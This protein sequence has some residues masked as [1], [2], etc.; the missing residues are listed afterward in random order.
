MVLGRWRRGGWMVLGK[1][2]GRMVLREV[3]GFFFKELLAVNV[4]RI[5]T[6]EEEDSRSEGEEEEGS[7]Q[8][9]LCVNALAVNVIII[10]TLEEEDSRSEEE[11]EEGTT[12]NGLCVNALAVN[13]IR[14]Q[15]SSIFLK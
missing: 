12:Q 11:E 6:L 10:Y 13:V 4:I 15:N 2:G 1:G 7:T 8:N 5:Y 14:I 3:V 9:G